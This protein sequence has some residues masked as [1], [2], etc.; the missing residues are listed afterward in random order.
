MRILI[1]VKNPIK[2]NLANTIVE[3][4]QYSLCVTAVQ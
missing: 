1:G 3:D 4:K 2:T